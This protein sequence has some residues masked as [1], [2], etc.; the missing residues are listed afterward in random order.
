VPAGVLSRG[1]RK[2][3]LSHPYNGLGLSDSLTSS[4]CPP[5]SRRAEHHFRFPASAIF[6][7]PHIRAREGAP[8]APCSVAKAGV[9]RPATLPRLTMASQP[10]GLWAAGGTDSLS[11]P[12]RDRA[13]SCRCAWILAR[14][15]DAGRFLVS[16]G[17][18]ALLRVAVR[19][20]SAPSVCVWP[21]HEYEHAERE[22]AGEDEQAVGDERVQ[23]DRVG[24]AR[25]P[26]QAEHQYGHDAEGCG[27]K[28]EHELVHEPGQVAAVALI[29]EQPN[30]EPEAPVL[31]Q[32]VI[33]S[34]R[35]GS[36][37]SIGT[38]E[39]SS[40][41]ALLRSAAGLSCSAR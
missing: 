6:P 24:D 28:R 31:E 11:D 10:V 22:D 2:W 14:P 5:A 30:V 39:I 40:S 7:G 27:Q 20:A 34:R 9:R 16:V 15:A 12:W 1:L 3:R 36:R 4:G 32:P 35:R 26:V 23:G 37:R 17:R 33:R 18:G 19:A 29:G 38:S 41:V 13:S 21:E 25:T 8:R